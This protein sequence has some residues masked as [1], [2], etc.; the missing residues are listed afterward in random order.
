[1]SVPYEQKASSGLAQ[2]GLKVAAE[3]LD[4]AA[5]QAAAGAWSYTHFLGYLLEGETAER[6]RKMVALSLKLSHLPYIKRLEDFD[7]SAQ[8]GVDRRLIDE[9]ATGRFLYEGRNIVFLGPPGVGKTHLAIAFGMIT[10]EMGH[11]IY[12]TTAIEM[13]RKLTKAIAE[14]RLHVEMNNL[15]RPKLLII[16]EVGYLSLDAPQASLLFQ[17]I[18]NRYERN[19]AIVLTS[20]KAFSEWGSVFAGDPV[21]AAA[22]LDR[23]LHRCTVINIRGES[24]RLK[25][26]RNAGT[27][28]NPKE[29][30]L[31]KKT[32]KQ[33]SE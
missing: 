24:Y 7:F 2:L 12:F 31:T 14:N 22:A 4:S 21:M 19:Q 9:L 5:Q 1:M 15:T 18:C 26:K 8:P 33:E 30:K 25:E 29:E 27:I 32:K 11:R 23:L 3:Q 13:A 16:D 20:N 10:A 28:E 6:H 17:A